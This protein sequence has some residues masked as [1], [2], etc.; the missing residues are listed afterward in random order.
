MRETTQAAVALQVKGMN[1][2][3][4][5]MGIEKYLKKTGFEGVR[6]DFATEEVFFE[7][8][9][10]KEIPGVIQGIESLGFEVVDAEQQQE[11]NAGL[12]R[13]EKL[14][15]FCMIWTL[16]LLLHM[17]VSWEF[18][19]KPYV[20]LLLSLPVFLAGIHHFGKSALGSLKSGVPN[21]DVLI[22]IGTS[23]AFFYSLYGTIWQL[24]PD[25]LFYE[26]AASIITLVLLG[27]VMEHRSVRKTTSAIRELA[28]LQPKMAKRIGRNGTET[29]IEEISI[30]EVRKKDIL[31]VNSGDQ[32]PVD[33]MVLSG[34]GE[35][36]ESAI[37]GESFPRSVTVGDGAIGGTVLINGSVQVLTKEIG[38]G[39]LLSQIIELVKQAQ[40][41][42]PPIQQLADKISAVFVP[43]VLAI[44]AVTF[45]LSWGVFGLSLQQALIHSVAVLVISCPCAMGLATP[46]AVVVGIG[47]AS[48]KGI[49]IKG[50]RTLEQFAK[51]RRVVFDKTGTLTSGEF[52]IDRIYA[53]EDEME[54]IEQVIYS[55]ERFSSHPIAKSLA[56]E[57]AQ[58]AMIPMHEVEETKGLGMQ[59]K[60][61]EGNLYQLGSFR[62]AAHLTQNNT[63]QLYLLKNGMLWACLDLKDK[64]RPE[65]IEMLT[66]FQ[67]RGIETIMLSGDRQAACDRVAQQLGITKVY[68]EKLP[69]EKLALIEQLSQD[70]PTAMVGDGI[71]DAPALAKA[72]VGISLGGATDI[73]IQS[74]QILL[75]NG[76]L[77]S[78]ESLHK[79]SRHTVLTIRQNLLWAFLYNVIAI[80]FAAVGMLK[81]ILA[82]AAMAL[83]DVMVIGNSLRLKIKSLS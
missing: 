79:I 63:H 35:I 62:L 39:T 80:P 13:I 7:Q 6:V 10:Q 51:I 56:K 49:L 50:G 77:T 17:F 54:K 29:I 34:E 11:D 42:K 74:A 73:A 48:R 68:A 69:Q 3:N 16:P 28:S 31:L 26:T 27:N 53:E 23:A 64:L 40:G 47:R 32:I 70:S 9:N 2:A 60:D 36:D 14:F 5:A 58:H 1:C 72:T 15:L 4:C 61:Q 55:L 21:M 33:G 12:S 81:P 71:N 41:D 25:F 24:G 37:T 30:T 59:G 45:L 75:I 52:S 76:K 44:A 82:A 22:S 67:S 57:L 66:Y 46:T 43:V 8:L 19:H 78:L 83:S 38:K 65:A 18:L 20:Q